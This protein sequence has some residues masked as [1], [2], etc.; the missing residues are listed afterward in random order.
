MSPRNYHFQ[1]SY[2]KAA[3]Q[4]HQDNID[5]SRAIWYAFTKYTG[6]TKLFSFT[7][8]SFQAEPVAKGQG[9]T[10]NPS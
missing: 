9:I 3:A 2:P 7:P 1:V 8:D 5:L 10:N 4:Q 6:I